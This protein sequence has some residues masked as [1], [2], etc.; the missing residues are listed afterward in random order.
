MAWQWMH[1]IAPGACVTQNVD[2]ENKSLAALGRSDLR[3]YC[4]H[5]PSVTVWHLPPNSARFGYANDGALF[6]SV[7]LS[8]DSQC[9]RKGLGTNK[10]V[11]VDMVSMHAHKHEAHPSSSRGKKKSSILIQMVLVLFVM[12]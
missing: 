10:T 4:G 7:Q 6:I 2:W 5:T 3:Q 11:G 12:V 9:P 8:T 1:V